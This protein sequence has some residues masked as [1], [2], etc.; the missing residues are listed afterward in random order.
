MPSVV[1]G[2][3]TSNASI[4]QAAAGSAD[5]AAAPGTGLRIHVT[6]IVLVANGA[7]TLK[8]QEGGTTDLTGNM[9]LPA[10]GMLVI[11]GNGVDPVISTV[12]ANS[13]LNLVTGTSFV[14]GWC[15]YFVE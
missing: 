1:A 12:T 11:L 4:V 5:I 7:C 10:N 6:Q 8:F 15:R 2:R 13:K 3:T 9:S 14:N